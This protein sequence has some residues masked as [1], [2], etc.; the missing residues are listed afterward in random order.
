MPNFTLQAIADHVGGTLKGDP[1]TQIIGIAPADA[2]KEGFLTFAENEHFLGKALQS[3]ASALLIPN[4]EITTDKP[5]IQ[6]EHVRVAFAKV[7]ALLHPEKRPNP[8]IHASAAIDPSAVVAPS[9]HI[10][11]HCIVESGARIGEHVVLK[12]H[13]HVGALSQIGD[14]TTVFPN[15]T[16]Y[17]STEIGKR[18]RIHA[19]TV[20]GSDG[21]GYVMDQGFHR[22]IPQ[23][24]NV[25]IGD[26]VEI[27]AN[28]TIDCGALGSTSI[29][30]GTK[31]D[32]LV[33][34]GHNVI[35]GD[36]SIVIAQVGIAGSSKI[37]NYVILAGQAGVAGHISIGDKAVVAGRS[38]VIHSIPEG[39]KWMGFP[40]QP[41]RRAKRQILALQQLPDLIKKFKSFI[42]EK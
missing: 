42:S 16:L 39:Q 36:H 1:D 13:V 17:P 11:P 12:G 5:Y 21:Y 34:I 37:G 9:A 25:V 10:G 24:G 23:V 35:I 8:G 30:K 15:V 41:D 38:G 28:T 26:D 40:A 2:A 14:E 32:N 33:Q 19:G 7:L 29:G 3:K 27:G 6:I 20:I 4:S 22:K 18:V 31:I